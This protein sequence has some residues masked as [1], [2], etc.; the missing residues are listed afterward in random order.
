MKKIIVL[1]FVCA[2]SEVS[3]AQSFIEA[4]EQGDAEAQY[5]V[6]YSYYV[7]K[8]GINKDYDKAVEWFR[9]SA[10]QGNPNAQR[11][12]GVCYENG[13][14]VKRDIQKAI[15]CYNQ[16][17]VNNARGALRHLGVC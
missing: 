12:L 5:Q 1:F 13:Y 16:A 17:I 2:F 7:G 14:G 11:R 8:N 15:E 9:K 4:A 3:M 6:G 10:D